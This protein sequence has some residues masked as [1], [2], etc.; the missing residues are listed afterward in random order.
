MTETER[1]LQMLAGILHEAEALDDAGTLAYLHGTI[2][3]KRQ[4]VAVPPI[5]PTSMPSCATRRSSAVSSRSSAISIC[6]C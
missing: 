3:T 6:A 4:P 1:A 2:S 5:R